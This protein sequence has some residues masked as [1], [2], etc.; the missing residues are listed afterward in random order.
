MP[1]IQAFL[2]FFYFL[3]PNFGSD[4]GAFDKALVLKS[5]I[6][7][8]VKSSILAFPIDPSIQSFGVHV[9]ESEPGGVP[10]T[11]FRPDGDK[12][13]LKRLNTTLRAQVSRPLAGSWSL[14][15]GKNQTFIISAFSSLLFPQLQILRSPK[16]ITD[17][18]IS[19][20]IPLAGEELSLRIGPPSL[21]GIPVVQLRN[22]FGQKVQ[23]LKT[24]SYLG[25][26]LL[27]ADFPAPNHSA[28]V[29][30]EGTYQNFLYLR[31]SKTR[32]EVSSLE[33]E[34]IHLPTYDSSQRMTILL[35]IQTGSLQDSFVVSIEPRSSGWALHSLNNPVPTS[36]WKLLRIESQLKGLTPRKSFSVRLHSEQVQVEGNY[37][38]F[39]L[40]DRSLSRTKAKWMKDSRTGCA[41]FFSGLKP[42]QPNSVSWSGVCS[43]EMAQGMGVL[44]WQNLQGGMNEYKGRVHSG[45][46]SGKGL[47]SLSD[48]HK[49]EGDFLANLYH[50]HGQLWESGTR[51]YQGEWRLGLMHGKG[52][53]TPVSHR[54]FQGQLKSGLPFDGKMEILEENK[55]RTFKIKDGVMS[56]TDE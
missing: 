50:G 36:K 53:W 2:F 54:K 30:V 20:G 35:A 52:V 42:I 5:T 41:L 24:R 25:G 7:S 6:P 12:H 33:M 17:S 8:T 19:S 39:S 18:R 49:Y 45:L 3:S 34:P 32:L 21:P 13:P 47:E 44:R 15:L 38:D 16:T 4:E 31:C 9:E 48:G 27:L 51:L 26:A 10:A 46:R 11:L 28:Q 1:G 29:C 23:V 56:S 37:L 14:H 55:P 40:Q 43:Q 22:R